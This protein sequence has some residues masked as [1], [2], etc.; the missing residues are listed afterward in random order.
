MGQHKTPVPWREQID[1]ETVISLAAFCGAV[2][3]IL[4][5]VWYV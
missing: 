3:L 5:L 2:L 1:T 4:S